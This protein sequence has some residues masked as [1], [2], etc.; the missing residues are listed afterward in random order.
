MVDPI[1][2][3]YHSVTP[4]L[5]VDDANAAIAFYAR[6]F[7]ATESL[8]LR[9]ATASRTRRSKSATRTACSPIPTPRRAF[10]PRATSVAPP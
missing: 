1:P 5:V 9:S 4:D 10:G 7:G 8:H 3:G 2:A 6:A